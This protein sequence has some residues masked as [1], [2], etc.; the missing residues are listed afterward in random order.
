MAPTEIFDSVA[1]HDFELTERP[2]EER[3]DAQQSSQTS[4]PQ[5]SI[6]DVPPKQHTQHEQF[7]LSPSQPESQT[8]CPRGIV[9]I[10]DADEPRARTNLPTTNMPVRD[11]SCGRS[12]TP[13]SL[14]RPLSSL[15]SAIGSE[16]QPSKWLGVSFNYEDIR[17]GRTWIIRI[18]KFGLWVVM[19]HACMAIVGVF[20]FITAIYSWRSNANN[21]IGLVV[22]KVLE[23]VSASGEHSRGVDGQLLNWKEV[24]EAHPD[25][26][27]IRIGEARHLR[28]TLLK[29]L[30]RCIISQGQPDTARELGDTRHYLGPNISSQSNQSLLFERN[31]IAL[32][33]ISQGKDLD[34]MPRRILPA[35]LGREYPGSFVIV[36]IMAIVTGALVWLVCFSFSRNPVHPIFRRTHL[37]AKKEYCD[38][39]EKS[40][41]VVDVADRTFRGLTSST[42]FAVSRSS[43]VH[44]NHRHFDIY[45]TAARGSFEELKNYFETDLLVCIDQVD[46]ANEYGTLLAAAARSG[47]VRKVN[48][49]LS[50]NPNLFLEGGRYHNALQA[51]AHSGSNEVVSRMLAAGAREASLGGFYGNAINAAAEKGT[52]TMLTNLLDAL[53]K[54]STNSTT[55]KKGS[56]IA[57]AAV[58]QPGGT[59]GYPLIAAAARGHITSVR[60]LLENGADVNRP[61]DSGT[62]ALH[63]AAVNGHIVVMD[64][65][66]QK[67]SFLDQLSTPFGTPLHAACRAPQTEAAKKLLKQGAD[68][69]FTDQRLR[70][71]LHE[72]A[73]VKGGL[74]QVIRQILQMRPELVDE[75]DNDGNTALNLASIAGNIDVV[76]ALLDH[77]ADCRIGDK[78]GMQPLFRATGCRHEQ[79][80]M[81][82]LKNGKVDTNATD[83]FGRTVLHEACLVGSLESV[84]LLLAQ[85]GIEINALDNAGFPPL[86]KVLCI[87]DF[88]TACPNKCA[89][90]S[91][92]ERLLERNELDVNVSNGIIVQEAARK[93]FAGFVEKMLSKHDANIHIQGGKYGSV[94]QA[95]AISGNSKL[96]DLLL[97]PTNHVDVSLSGGEFGCPLAAAAAFGHIEIVQRLLEAGANPKVTGVGRYGSPLQ[98]ICQKMDPSLKI[99]DERK[100]KSIAR[101]IRELLEIHGASQA[102]KKSDRRSPRYKDWRQQLGTT[103]WGWSPP[104]KPSYF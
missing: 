40:P 25:P 93:G 91:I 19:F 11:N 36:G 3:T 49:V 95:A 88:N 72:A 17:G 53:P 59:Y 74:D 67:R 43:L 85:P 48:Y 41:D 23:G 86:Y 2:P 46:K 66:F 44:R 37:A 70:T 61:N 92:V 10:V 33:S 65:L 27:D 68:P 83:S 84:D 6:N 103:E 52:P 32:S 4:H 13:N 97:T 26:E 56:I 54:V 73:L 101:Q 28:E 63:Q 8:Q 21:D 24:A 50:K 18:T 78:F 102:G 100:S 7:D 82:L 87:L 5:A 81:E 80:V 35:R 42:D 34:I 89:G 51:A 75:L 99:K 16:V 55:F 79:I 58:N 14:L 76:K 90:T 69:R 38:T 9:A 60:V 62:I 57:I 64:L 94:L 98:S 77:D 30:Q 1:F 22:Q 15:A 29:V 20:N 104:G 12:S 31:P 96:V 47:D 39:D 71:P 45:A